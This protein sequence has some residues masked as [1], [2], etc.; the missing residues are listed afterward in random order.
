MF[1]QLI[2]NAAGK[3]KPAVIDKVIMRNAYR[4]SMKVPLNVLRFAPRK[5]R[6]MVKM[7]MSATMPRDVTPTFVRAFAVLMLSIIF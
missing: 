4:S 1:V 6:K 7:P 2:M 5:A 3:Q